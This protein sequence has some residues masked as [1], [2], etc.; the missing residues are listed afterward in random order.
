M[1]LLQHQKGL[2][3]VAEEHQVGLPASRRGAVIGLLRSLGQEPAVG[4][5]RGGEDLGHSLAEVGN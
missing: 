3:M 1:A 4:D 2:P 5:E